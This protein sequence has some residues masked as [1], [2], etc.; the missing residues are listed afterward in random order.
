M[1]ITVGTWIEATTAEHAWEEQRDTPRIRAAFATLQRSRD[2]WPSP[3]AFLDALPR[4]EQRAIGY[5][6][7]PLTKEQADA[8]LAEIRSLLKEP[9]PE[10]KP[11]PK[12]RLHCDT[13]AE[14][15]EEAMR[16]LQ[17]HRDGKA[18][19]AGSDA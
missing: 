14:E 5:Q 11:E 2:T 12:A 15:R 13:T 17:R 4:L 10:F 18:P 3:K 19:A 8:R 6:V 9:L 16:E 1:E 7:K